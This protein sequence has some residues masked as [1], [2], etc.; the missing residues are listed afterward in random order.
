MSAPVAVTGIGVVGA[1]G[2]GLEALARCLMGA[3][4]ET[5][6]HEVD[7]GSLEVGQAGW[8]LRQHWP[9]LPLKLGRV[10]R[11]SKLA[12]IAGRQALDSAGIDGGQPAAVVIGSRYGCLLVNEG[13]HRSLLTKGYRLASPLLFGYTVPSA[14]AGELSI[15][16]GL[17]GPNLTLVDGDA[18]GG[19][20]VARAADWIR[21]GRVERAV[22]GGV[23]AQGQWLA[24]E[25]F[26]GGA[27]D[28]DRPVP[29][30]GAALVVLESIESARERGAPIRTLVG[31]STEGFEPAADGRRLPVDPLA[32]AIGRTYAAAAPLALAAM[33]GGLLA[34]EPIR[35]ED[36]LGHHVQLDVSPLGWG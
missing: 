29:A 13:Y 15:A 14:P 10:D 35:V 23:D 17:T 20:A 22:A 26:D 3:D 30:E 2:V 32:D 8:K 7:G 16:A 21:S 6:R 5:A 34:P 9:G 18:A 31:A 11:G 27:R 19:A 25:L 12:L 36:E 4:L 24:Q 33:A 1:F 28:G